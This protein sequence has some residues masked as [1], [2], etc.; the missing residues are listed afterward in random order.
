ME[1]FF[2][3]GRR[4]LPSWVTTFPHAL[5]TALPARAEGRRNFSFISLRLEI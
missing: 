5:T 4:D 2:F 3:D 1:A